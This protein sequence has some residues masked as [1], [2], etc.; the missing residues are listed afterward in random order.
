MDFL[1]NLGISIEVSDKM[2]HPFL[3]TAIQSQIQI[4][5]QIQA[6]TKSGTASVPLHTPVNQ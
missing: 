3:D 5:K 2:Q 6:Q 1:C 4:Q